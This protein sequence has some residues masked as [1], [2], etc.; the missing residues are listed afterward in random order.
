MMLYF[1]NK[2]QNEPAVQGL[3]E[4][5]SYCLLISRQPMG[6]CFLLSVSSTVQKYALSLVFILGSLT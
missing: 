5:Q 4:V 3:A 2:V 1:L 6:L